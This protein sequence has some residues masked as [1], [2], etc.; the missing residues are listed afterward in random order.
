ML[1]MGAVGVLLVSLVSL[2]VR[3][4]KA[5]VNC[6]R[7]WAASGSTA[8]EIGTCWRHELETTVHLLP[9]VR[10]GVGNVDADTVAKG[11]VP[12]GVCP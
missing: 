7:M 1:A 12:L 10:H 8:D 2:S 3:G 5:L 6:K 11:V 4:A 9:L